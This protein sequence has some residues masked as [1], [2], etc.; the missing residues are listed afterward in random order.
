MRD[1]L[2]LFYK[3]YLQKTYNWPTV[4]TIALLDGLGLGELPLRTLVRNT[5]ALS[6]YVGVINY[7]H[8]PNAE[9]DFFENFVAKLG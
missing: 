1:K 2:V 5:V 3:G 9:I 4:S 7:I 8:T 6:V